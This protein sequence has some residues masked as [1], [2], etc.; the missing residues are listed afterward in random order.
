MKKTIL[1]L[2]LAAILC[3]STACSPSANTNV[4]TSDNTVSMEENN[5]AGA[6]VFGKVKSVVG[7]EIELEIAEP[8]FDLDAESVEGSGDSQ[9]QTK[10]FIYEFEEGEEPPEGVNGLDVTGEAS[11]GVIIAV[12]GEDGEMK[13]IGGEDG[14]KMDLKYTGESKSVII[15][16]GIK[17]MNLIGS[18]TLEDIKKGSVLMITVDDETASALKALD[19]IIM[20]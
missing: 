6:I 13:V 9:I 20:E 1:T 3:I 17:I 10:E 14:E 11:S 16:T 19:V 12:S 18:G 7:N 5:E 4:D 2:T 8:P 15:P